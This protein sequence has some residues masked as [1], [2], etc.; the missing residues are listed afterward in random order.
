ME[1]DEEAEAVGAA[2]ACEPNA[3]VPDVAAR[4]ASARSVRRWRQ[5]EDKGGG[6]KEKT[7][8]LIQ[9]IFVF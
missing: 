2:S 6:S 1:V 7:K 8:G 5:R 9:Y 3:A 4:A